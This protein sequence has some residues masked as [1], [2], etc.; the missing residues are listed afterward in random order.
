MK[1]YLA[2]AVSPKHNHSAHRDG[3]IHTT[4]AVLR[5]DSGINNVTAVTEFLPKGEFG[6]TITWDAV[7]EIR[8]PLSQE[9]QSY[10]PSVKLHAEH[11]DFRT[12]QI[13]MGLRAEAISDTY[14]QILR[15]MVENVSNVRQGDKFTQEHVADWLESVR[16]ALPSPILV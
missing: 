12:H 3:F 1:E 13:L 9:I 14:N 16:L 8:S 10:K 4:I 11:F 6:I 7:V 5:E 2:I 15:D